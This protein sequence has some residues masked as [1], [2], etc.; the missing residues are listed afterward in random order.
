M[1]WYKFKNKFHPSWHTSVKEFIESNECN[2]IY[3][4]LKKQTGE[5]APKSVYTFKNFTKPLKDIK[6]VLIFEE[7]YSDKKD[8]VQYADGTALDC[9]NVDKIHPYLDA[10][11]NA[12]EKEFYDLNLHTIKDTHL[13]FYTNQGVMFLTSSLTTEIGS[14]GKHKGLWIP[15]IKHLIKNVFTKRGIPIVFCGWEVQREYKSV[16]DPIYPWFIIQQPISKTSIGSPWSTENVFTKLNDYLW[17][18]TDEEDI[19]WVKQEVPF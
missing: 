9:Y 12:M 18:K 5:I 16:L 7:P 11:Y 15:F 3:S 14:P 1:N 4:F 13:D 2:K 17:D 19:M 6:V 8:G 10:F